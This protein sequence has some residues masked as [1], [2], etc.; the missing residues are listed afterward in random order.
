MSMIE[1]MLSEEIRDKKRTGNGIHSKTGSRGYTGK[2]LFPADLMNSKQ[3]RNYQRSGVVVTWNTKEVLPKMEFDTYEKEQQK[4]MLEAWRTNF[5]NKEIMKKMGLTQGTFYSLLNVVGV[6][7]DIKFSNRS[8]KSVAVSPAKVIELV[9]KKPT[10]QE[11]TAPVFTEGLNFNIN[12]K[13]EADVL[14]NWLTK[15]QMLVEGTGEYDVVIHLREK[16]A[17]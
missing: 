7:K 8:S 10:I 4:E 16:K 14:S 15:L 6:N 13:Y 1:R 2:I 12:G 9:E 5:T 3:K 17:N 11:T